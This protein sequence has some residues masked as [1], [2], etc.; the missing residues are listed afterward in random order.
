[1]S[2]SIVNENIE[3]PLVSV[4]TPVYNGHAYLAESIESV[5]SQTYQNW[6]LI[7]LNNGSSDDSLAL[8]NDYA[9]KDAR[10]KVHS[11]NETLPQMENWNKSM[12]LISEESVYCKVVHADDWLFPNCLQE[13]VSLCVANPTVALVGSY[14][15][16]EEAVT[17]DGLVYPSHCVRGREIIRR[18]FLGSPDL[19]GSPT[20]VMYR[21]DQVLSRPEFYNELNLHADTEICF[22]ILLDHDFGFVH[23]VLTFTR[24]HNETT[25]TYAKRMQTYKAC[26]LMMLKSIGT[27]VLNE[28]E[29]HSAVTSKLKNYYRFLGFRLLQ[30]RK[31]STR[32]FWNEFWGY[33]KESLNAQGGGFSWPRVV[34]GSGYSVYKSIL[35]KINFD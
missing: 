29:L 23:Q 1:M 25:S 16:E 21:S 11:N 19:F 33:H 14:R 18:R 31:A 7:I 17:L 24:R 15:L 22:R 9:E 26:D 10:I 27:E 35:N 28:L 3:Q 2:R 20:S 4:V 13:M 5:L 12:S 6:E 8:A 34:A 30:F 32:D